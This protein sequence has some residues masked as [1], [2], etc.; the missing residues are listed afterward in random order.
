MLPLNSLPKMP[1]I[2][3]TITAS[4]TIP[5]KILIESDWEILKARPLTDDRVHTKATSKFFKGFLFQ[6][7]PRAV[8]HVCSGTPLAL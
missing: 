3:I 7:T 1:I 4:I 2:I 6:N 8:L 5:V